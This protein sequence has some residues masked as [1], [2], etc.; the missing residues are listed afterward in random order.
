M[1]GGIFPGQPFEFNIKCI[2][3]TAL[4]AGGYWYLPPKNLWVLAFLLWFPYIAMAWYDYSYQCQLKKLK[5]TLVPFGRY[6]WLP[7]KPQGYKDEF[8][9]MSAEQIQAMD[10]LDHIV[11]WT[12]VAGAAAYFILNKK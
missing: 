5:P 12:I 7:F 3:F 9:K 6:I 11:G 4:L 2:V 8:N 1:A 10:R